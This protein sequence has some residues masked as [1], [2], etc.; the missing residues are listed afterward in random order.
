MPETSAPVTDIS[1]PVAPSTGIEERV[2]RLEAMVG[3]VIEL[4][5]AK[6][7][8]PVGDRPQIEDPVEAPQEESLA[9][10]GEDF[11]LEETLA[12]VTA[13]SPFTWLDHPSAGGGFQGMGTVN[14]HRLNESQISRSFHNEFLLKLRAYG[15]DQQARPSRFEPL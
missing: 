4:L 3:R 7:A 1:E 5:E 8:P 6:P 15:I 10:P 9:L 2:D 11:D 12:D 13:E 14:G